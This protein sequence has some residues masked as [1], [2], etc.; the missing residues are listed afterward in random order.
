MKAGG[1]LER[2]A[3]AGLDGA[4]FFADPPIKP[5]APAGAP[6]RARGGLTPLPGLD[7]RGDHLPVISSIDIYT[8]SDARSEYTL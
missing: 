2:Q 5:G 1:R 8:S 4:Q 3:N 7:V 6:D